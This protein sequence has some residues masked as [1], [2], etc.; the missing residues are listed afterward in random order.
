MT[1][2]PPDLPLTP[3]PDD[4]L[5]VLTGT[6][7]V[8]REGTL[9]TL[10]GD[11]IARLAENWAGHPWPAS[12]IASDFATMH[13]NDGTERTANWML[14]VDAL[15]FCF[16]GEP[17]EPRWSVEWRGQTW[18][19]Y[20]ALAAA[21]T[22]A[23]DEGVPLADA[24][25]LANLTADQLAEVLRPAPGCPPIPLFEERLANAREVGRVLGERYDG[26]MSHVIEAANYDAVALAL[27]LARDFSS[28]ADVAEW[29]EQPVPLLKRAQICVAD[30]H[31]AF[32]GS[33]WGSLRG[34]ERLTAFADYK[35]PQMLR[36]EGVL[37]YEPELAELIASY[38]LI[39]SG[40]DAEVEIRAATVWAV[41]LLRQALARAGIQQTAS[42]I[43]YR[44][45]LESQ[46]APPDGIPYHRTRTI[47]Y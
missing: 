10:D 42:A 8:A 28:F 29:N 30:M 27:R 32:G 19:G 9:V 17:G 33:G 7:T 4:A 6:A 15:N 23:M 20:Y 13:F 43:D 25:F 34:I 3:P 2:S 1:T 16:W 35:L 11:A 26:Q 40:A 41:E 31:T 36:R 45:W 12:D 5:G 24:A 22:R 18:D 44:I 47:Y 14:L 21:C 37:V 39:P 46:S 38:T